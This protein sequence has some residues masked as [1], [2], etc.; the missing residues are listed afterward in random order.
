MEKD[1]N[2]KLGKRISAYI[3]DILIASLI[4]SLVTLV[5]FINPN[6]DKYLEASNKYNEVLQE[7]Y[8][9]KM[10][11]DEMV[12]NNTENYYLVSKYGIS[13]SISAFVILF[14][15][16]VLFPVFT[17]G[18]TIGKKI[19]KIKIVSNN[20][21]N[22]NLGN[23]L[24]RSL[25]IYYLTIGSLIPFILNTILIFILSSNTYL[26]ANSVITY[27]FMAIYMVSVILILIRKDKRGLHEVISNTKVVNEEV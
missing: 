1:N 19:M 9:G 10:T 24:L 23:Y 22:L 16:F 21:Q 6:Y 7:Y 27:T 15:Y 13:Y 25:P 20:N 8:D 12:K 5:R 4:F 17:K 26:I 3:L 18:Q 14:G 11:A 2:V